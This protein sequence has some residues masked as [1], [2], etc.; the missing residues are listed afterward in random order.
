MSR[1]L[2]AVVLLAACLLGTA[3]ADDEKVAQAEAAVLQWLAHVDDR[4]YVTSWND[5]A[6]PFRVRVTPQQWEDA[7]SAG[8]E[9]F[10]ELVSRTVSDA[11]YTTSVPGLPDGEFVIFQF[12]SVFEHKAEGVETVTAVLEEDTWRVTG[13]F[14][15]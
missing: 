3:V 14:I 12:A 10:G 15:R 1:K 8:R 9:P 11:T 2:I 13:Y 6:R 5:A 7:V 4:Q